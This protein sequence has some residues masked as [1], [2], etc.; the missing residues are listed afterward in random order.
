MSPTLLSST[1]F[2]SF[3]ECL[4]ICGFKSLNGA[5]RFASAKA[6]PIAIRNRVMK[7]G[8]SWNAVP[9]AAV[10]RLKRFQCSAFAQQKLYL[11]L[12]PIA[13]VNVS[14]RNDF[15]LVHYFC[16]LPLTESS[17]PLFFSS[18]LISSA[19]RRAY[20]HFLANGDMTIGSMMGVNLLAASKHPSIK[21]KLIRFAP[22]LPE[23]GCKRSASHKTIR[24]H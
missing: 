24:L 5:H 16:I 12:A 23:H 14:I 4:A 2:F 3:R 9:I 1:C 22:M 10:P 11:C 13:L 19:N 18:Y 6:E 8:R 21:Y 17:P 20:F 15:F 7:D